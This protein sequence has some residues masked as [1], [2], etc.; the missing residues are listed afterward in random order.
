[1]TPCKRRVVRVTNEINGPSMRPY[2]IRL[3][4]GGKTVSIKIK[5]KRS[6]FTVSIRQIWTMG[7]WN[8]AA[9]IRAEKKRK[10]EERK[11]L[12]ESMR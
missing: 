7:A 9:V 10:K 12:R 8:A 4:P 11:K 3:D 1:M 2:V 6:W 5:G